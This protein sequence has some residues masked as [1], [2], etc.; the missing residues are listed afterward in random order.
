MEEMYRGAKIK[1]YITIGIAALIIIMV[2]WVGLGFGDSKEDKKPKTEAAD[3]EVLQKEKTLDESIR[4]KFSEELTSLKEE[5]IKMQKDLERLARDNANMLQKSEK[6][7][8]KL[9]NDNKNASD[10]QIKDLLD[11]MKLA[12]P[13]E[14]KFDNLTEQ[15][16]RIPPPPAE[17]SD[18]ADNKNDG[19]M[20]QGN[21][22]YPSY[23]GGPAKINT[24]PVITVMTGLISV[25]ESKLQE[26]IEQITEKKVIKQEDLIIPAGSFVKAQLASG[27]IAPT[28]G[29]GA[30]DPVPALLRVTGLTQ[31]P[32]FFKADIKNCFLLAET[33]GNLATETVN[34]RL[35]T[36]SCKKND[37]TTIE[38]EVSGYVTGENGMEGMAGR[39][40]SKQGAIIARAF[41]AEFASGIGDAFESSGTTTSITGAGIIETLDPSKTAQTGLASGLSEAFSRL[42][43][44]YMDLAEQMVPVIEINAGRNVD[45]VFIKSVDLSKSQAEINDETKK[46]QALEKQQRGR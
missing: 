13:G 31:L 25:G 36:L 4:A 3:V 18:T 46:Q 12:K 30:T 23:P 42:G 43:D 14:S 5:N 39:V 22:G 45:V 9:I 37:G 7:Q 11:Q 32:N 10:R 34:F 21:N 1:R 24:A 15:A 6:A 16:N 20:Y 44:F 41:L 29:Q 17:L 28:G 35:K 19:K 8:Q 26:D 40:V 2:L 38:R 27:V 33:K